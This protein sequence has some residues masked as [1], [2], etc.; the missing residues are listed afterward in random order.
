MCEAGKANL[1]QAVKAFT[2]GNHDGD[3]VENGKRMGI[4]EEACKVKNRKIVSG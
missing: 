1:N 4:V 2:D 3:G